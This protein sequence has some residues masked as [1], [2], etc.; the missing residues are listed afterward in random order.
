MNISIIN[1][2]VKRRKFRNNYSMDSAIK[3][4]NFGE[5]FRKNT[6]YSNSDYWKK[7][8]KEMLLA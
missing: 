8:L 5:R 6:T 7:Y 2:I 1:I 3:E 4:I